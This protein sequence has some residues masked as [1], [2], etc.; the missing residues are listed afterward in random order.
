MPSTTTNRNPLAGS[1]WDADRG[2]RGSW[3]D[4]LRRVPGWGHCFRGGVFLG[5][6]ALLVAGAA[7]WML[8]A[9]LTM[10]LVF[11]GLWLWASEFEWGRRIFHAFVRRGRRMLKDVA[12]RPRRWAGVTVTGLAAGAGAYWVIGRYDLVSAA[13]GAVGL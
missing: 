11:A 5:G 9:L 3:R 6:L 12:A 7:A 4:R 10:P 13:L 8:T 1:R 2:P